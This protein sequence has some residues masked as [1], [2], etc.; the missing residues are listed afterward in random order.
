ML[1]GQKEAWARREVEEDFWQGLSLRVAKEVVR[2]LRQSLF[3]SQGDTL[4]GEELVFS[5]SH[6][7]YAPLR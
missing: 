5:W 2:Q 3:D 7:P 4:E 1:T 6:D